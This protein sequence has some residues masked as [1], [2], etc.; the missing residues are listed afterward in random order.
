MSPTK[1]KILRSQASEAHLR[2]LQYEI[3]QLTLSFDEDLM[4]RRLPEL[5]NLL[6]KVDKPSAKDFLKILYKVA[7]IL[8]EC[9]RRMVYV[10]ISAWS[11]I[12]SGVSILYGV[13]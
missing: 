12:A 6:I 10:S 1:P 8:N 7:S 11:I 9:R 5:M 13:N 2:D 4:F 3:E